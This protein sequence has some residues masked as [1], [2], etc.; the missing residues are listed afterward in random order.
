M[1]SAD[2]RASTCNISFLNAA[3]LEK[4]PSVPVAAH[5]GAVPYP[6]WKRWLRDSLQIHEQIRLANQAGTDLS[7]E[8]A[9]ITR[10]RP[11]IVLELLAHVWKSQQ[12]TVSAKPELMTKI[13]NISVP[14]RAG[15]PRPLWE[16][17]MPFKHLQRRCLE[18]MKPNE[19]FPF[20][21]LGTPPPS[22]EDLSRNWQFLYQDLGVSK[23]DDLGLLLD[24][25]SYIQE[26]NPHGLSSL[27]CREVARL[28]CEM[29]AACVASEEPDCARDICRS[30][31]Q[32]INGIAI[33]PFAG[34]GPRWVDVKQ[35]SWDGQAVTTTKIPLRYVYEDVLQCSPQELAILYSF[36]SH[37]LK[38][39]G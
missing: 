25:L 31:I 33:P 37:L 4:S 18:F 28:Y 39:P 32:D 9:Q 3:L 22:T 13:R 30:F 8:F 24:I 15:G 36:Y 34:H 19:P 11:E 23:N 14:C 26:A 21:D 5:F 10:R 27:R 17:Y 6:T 16:T 20:L 2:F 29:E 38:C 7:D 1:H 12:K 35:C